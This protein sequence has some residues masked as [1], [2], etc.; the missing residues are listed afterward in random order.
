MFKS[1]TKWF[2]KDRDGDKA[3]NV[4]QIVTTLP[5]ELFIDIITFLPLNDIISILLLSKEYYKQFNNHSLLFYSLCHVICKNYSI[6]LDEIDNEMNELQNYKQCFANLF[7]K[8]INYK[9]DTSEPYYNKTE[10]YNK[11]YTLTNYDK[12]IQ[13]LDKPEHGEFITIHATKELK[14]GNRYKIIFKLDN[15][16]PDKISNTF[17]VMVG[18]ESKYFFPWHNQSSSDVIGWNKYDLG[19]SFIVAE[20][21]QLSKPYSPQHYELSNCSLQYQFKSGDCIVMEV[22]LTKI[23]KSSRNR[24]IEQQELSCKELY[25]YSYN[26]KDKYIDYSALIRFSVIDCSSRDLKH[27]GEWIS[28]GN[29][30]VTYVPAVSINYGQTVSIYGTESA[31][32]IFESK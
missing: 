14:K 22:D 10:Y 21:K 6:S 1:L 3:K 30:H 25:Y 23:K 29:S 5:T 20:Q 13:I 32:G 9:F 11:Y 18:V 24:D 7:E 31:A 27:V 12:T 16:D 28:F 2:I 4:L 26:T 15:Y 8:Y 19:I 17:K